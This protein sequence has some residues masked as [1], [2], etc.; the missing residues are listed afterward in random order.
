MQWRDDFW[1]KA[2]FNNLAHLHLATL[3]DWPSC[4]FLNAQGNLPIAFIEQAKVAEDLGY[5]EEIIYEHKLV[6]TREH[7]W[8][9]LF[10][11]CIWLN[12]PQSKALLNQQ[13]IEDIRQFGLNPRTPRRNRIT[14]F[15][16]C[17]VILAYSQSDIPMQLREHQW[18]KSFVE[19]RQQWGTNIEALIFGH[20]NYEMLL[21]P[22]IG[23]T[24]KFIAI[25]VA[26]DYWQSDLAARYELLDNALVALIK[27]DCF[28]HKGIMSPLPLLGVP[29]WW[30]ENEFAEFY[31]NRGYFMPKR[32]SF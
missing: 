24:A 23:L 14:H 20:A 25:E 27:Q 17:G 26:D 30:P 29:G 16:E 1:C 22:Y 12:F 8:H 4:A 11:A 2:P 32:Q 19:Q 13:H 15:D 28:A 18:Q 31:D 5:Y 7:S 3:N 21:Q 6:P 10:N 9:D